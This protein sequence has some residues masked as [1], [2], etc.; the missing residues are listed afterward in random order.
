MKAII[1]L[2]ALSTLVSGCVGSSVRAVSAADLRASAAV[3]DQVRRCYRSPRIPSAGKQIV[4]RLLV[5]YAPDG[6]L[7]GLPLVVWQQ[8]ITSGNQSYAG[9]MAEAASQAVV[10]CSPVA[11]PPESGKVP[12][13]E[14]YLT[15][16]P[17][18]AA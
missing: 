18:L 6:A 8:G 7:S 13:S 4:T 17:Q 11:L 2:L 10:R 16:S 9:R 14:F 3:A 5:R 1:S 15:F 12:P